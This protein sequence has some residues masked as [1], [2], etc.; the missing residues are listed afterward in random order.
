MCECRIANASKNQT[1]I[2]AMIGPRLAEWESHDRIEPF[3]AG[4]AR[5]VRPVADPGETL[6][7]AAPDPGYLPPSTACGSGDLRR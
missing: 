7:A 1:R 3:F 6:R 4:R 2:I 5:F